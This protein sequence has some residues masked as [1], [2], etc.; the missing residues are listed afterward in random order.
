MARRALRHGLRSKSLAWAQ[1]I[2]ACDD[3]AK[4]RK[5]DPQDY[6]AAHTVATVLADT[7]RMSVVL[8]NNSDTNSTASK[9]GKV[10]SVYGGMVLKLLETKP[11]G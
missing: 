6:P 2:N 4:V 11:K 9:V 8:D 1:A 3:G 7:R 5:Y 10:G